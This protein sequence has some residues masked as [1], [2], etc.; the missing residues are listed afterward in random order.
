MRF[1]IVVDDG[2]G[3]SAAPV[4]AEV[5]GK[6]GATS[7]IPL[8]KFLLDAGV[9]FDK[10]TGYLIEDDTDSSLR[11]RLEDVSICNRVVGVSDETALILDSHT[12]VLKRNMVL[13][14]FARILSVAPKV[15]GAV[16]P[17]P[18][19]QLLPLN[20]QWRMI[21]KL[22]TNF[23]TPR[24][25]YAFGGEVPNTSGF[26]QPLWKD[27]FE[28]YNWESGEQEK[29]SVHFVVEKPRGNPAIVYFVGTCAEVFALPSFE[30]AAN[31]IRSLLVDVVPMLRQVFRT[32]MGEALFF[33]DDSH[34]VFAALS[35]YLKT[36]TN[37]SRFK[38]LVNAGLTQ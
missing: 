4:V 37:H 34:V 18:A 8:S 20:L 36:A 21:D 13:A 24:F 25:E 9:H 28:L 3:D 6:R 32:F 23:A 19:S 38:E 1:E 7:I 26:R 15:W 17:Y 30:N 29:S 10:E 16:E 11:A 27:P 2:N 33:V 31:S 22:A 5:L 14:A 35:R 12:E